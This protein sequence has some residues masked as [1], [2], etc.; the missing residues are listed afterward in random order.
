LQALGEYAIG[1]PP[2]S[3]EARFK[4]LPHSR[5]LVSRWFGPSAL[6]L[7]LLGLVAVTGGSARADVSSLLILRPLAVLLA[8]VAL[9][10]LPASRMGGY[11]ALWAL[12]AAAVALLLLHLIPLPPALW[13]ALPGRELVVQIDRASG[14]GDV[15]RPFSLNPLMTRN[16][17]WA[18]AVPIATVALVVQLDEQGIE[19]SL[20]AVLAIG[21]FSG[22]LGVL[23]FAG[24]P[25]SPFYF[26]D[27]TNN[28]SAVGLLANRNHE[29]VFLATLFPLLAVNATRGRHD[30]ADRNIRVAGMVTLAAMLLPMIL[31][32]GSRAG[33]ATAAIGLAGALVIAWPRLRKP[34]S[35]RRTNQASKTW[36]YAAA[37]AVF[38]I[39]CVTM[40]GLAHGNSF[41][42]LLGG[43]DGARELRWPFWQVTAHA[44]AKFFPFGAGLGSFVEVFKVYEPDNLLGL[45]YANHAHNDYVELFLDGGLPAVT[46]VL[47]ALAVVIRDGVTVWRARAGNSRVLLGR[48][49]FVSLMLFAIASAFDYPLRTPLLAAIACVHAVWL[50]RGALAA[51]TG[52]STEA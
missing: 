5:S 8:G 23:Q 13:Q 33:L 28:G 26:Y 40:I 48:A 45:T 31:G 6:L 27:I 19:R 38:L 22:L 2:R 41:D 29:G 46:L 21:V 39:V 18:M 43:D 49:A 50:R 10:R 44:G 32:T 25:N 20:I 24:G 52:D 17:L 47:A 11:R 14:L 30:G 34:P 4:P 37:A 15:W 7:F 1:P 12:L 35:A 51:R 42:R 9:M 3:L 36:L 16:A